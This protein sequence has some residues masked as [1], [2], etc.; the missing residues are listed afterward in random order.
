MKV[1]LHI[2]TGQPYR[3]ETTVLADATLGLGSTTGYGLEA[4]EYAIDAFEAARGLEVSF[5][6]TEQEAQNLVTRLQLHI[7]RNT[8]V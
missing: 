7:Q 4:A 2:I 3:A 1:V 6:L 8:G 5:R